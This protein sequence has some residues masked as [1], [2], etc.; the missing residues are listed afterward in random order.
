MNLIFLYV[1]KQFLRYNKFFSVR[2]LKGRNQTY[3]KH[4]CKK[5]CVNQI[6]NIYRVSDI[7]IFYCIFLKISQLKHTFDCF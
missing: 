6:V 1:D 5:I 3:C 4:I 7:S 2:K